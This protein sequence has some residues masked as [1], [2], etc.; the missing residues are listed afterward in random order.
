[1]RTSHQRGII[2][3][4]NAL[5]SRI[6]HHRGGRKEF[7]WV[8][9]FRSRIPSVGV[10]QK[11]CLNIQSE[12]KSFVIFEC[13]RWCVVHGSPSPPVRCVFRVWSRGLYQ[14]KRI[15]TSATFRTTSRGTPSLLLSTQ[16]FYSGPPVNLSSFIR[17]FSTPILIF[18]HH[19]P[20]APILLNPNSTGSSWAKSWRN[21]TRDSFSFQSEIKY[22]HQFLNVIMKNQLDNEW[23]L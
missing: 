3:K 22:L 10:S 21:D 15:E 18:K 12:R 2:R 4:S 16:Q 1:M 17:I 20:I 7:V 5:L 6:L 13:N 19:V 11:A 9:R 8:E 23:S 14:K